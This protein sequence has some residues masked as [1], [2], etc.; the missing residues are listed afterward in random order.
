[1]DQKE[2]AEIDNPGLEA[3]RDDDPQTSDRTDLPATFTGPRKKVN[4]HP[5]YPRA[6][7][8]VYRRWGVNRLL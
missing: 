1:M 2:R 6:S 4:P 8:G 7:A 3:P 5:V